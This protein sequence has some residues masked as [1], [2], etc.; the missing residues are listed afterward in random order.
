M[1][2]NR[3]E[4][5]FFVIKVGDLYVGNQFVSDNVNLTSCR[6]EAFPFYEEPSM[7]E[8]IHGKIKLIEAHGLKDIKVVKVVKIN[9]VYEYEYRFGRLPKNQESDE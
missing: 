8:T 3:D 2:K 1:L 9:E 7:E 5:S 4:K 6:F